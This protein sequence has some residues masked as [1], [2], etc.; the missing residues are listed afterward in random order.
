MP[1]GG[2]GRGADTGPHK[3]R[4]DRGHG[5]PNNGRRESGVPQDSGLPQLLRS[6][7][8]AS[9]SRYY[10][11]IG[12]KMAAI[13]DS[14]RVSAWSADSASPGARRLGWGPTLVV[15]AAGLN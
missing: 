2:G 10:S 15:R 7:S 11:G 8:A 5:L 14:G 6:P 3:G 12:L 13:G 1:P 9:Q 4:P